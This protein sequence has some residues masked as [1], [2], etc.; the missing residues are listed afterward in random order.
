L[1]VVLLFFAVSSNKKGFLRPDLADKPSAEH[2][3][4]TRS[5]EFLK[6]SNADEQDENHEYT[7]GVEIQ[8][9]D[10]GLAVVACGLG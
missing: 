5:R 3:F 4:S 6:K 9:G 10:F 8:S 7:L 1:F 2:R